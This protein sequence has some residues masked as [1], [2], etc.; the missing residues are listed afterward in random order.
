MLPIIVEQT[1]GARLIS[2]QDA[3]VTDQAAWLRYYKGDLKE[4]E[5][6]LSGDATV[7]LV[8][9]ADPDIMEQA[10]QGLDLSAVDPDSGIHWPLLRR[11]TRLCV[12]GAENP[13]P[14][15]PKPPIVREQG[16]RC[17]AREIAKSL[18]RVTC[19]E[20]GT[21]AMRLWNEAKEARGK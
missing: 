18:P 8:R 2:S 12:V 6:V 10:A 15:W 21:L 14:S 20:I 5:L 3:A 11:I 13:D 19:A 17:L 9:A 7:F 16:E 4:S 1:G